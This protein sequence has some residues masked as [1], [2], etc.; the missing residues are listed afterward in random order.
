MI[1]RILLPLDSSVFSHTAI[2][3]ASSIAKKYDAEVIGITI[4]DIPEIEWS[5][6]SFNSD[7]SEKTEVKLDSLIRYSRDRNCEVVENF[8]KILRRAGISHSIE[9]KKG[10]PTN[11]IAS[12][13]IFYNLVVTGICSDFNFHPDRNN[14]K[15]IDRLLDNVMT[16]VLAVPKKYKPI[17]NVLVA[18]NGS[19]QAVNA[20]KNFTH[21]ATKF[22]FTITL[23]MSNTNKHYFKYN[24]EQVREY[25]NRYSLN[26]INIECTDLS[27]KKAYADKFADWTD[28]I[29]LG[30]HSEKIGTDFL[31]D[32]FTKYLI[33]EENKAL[34]LG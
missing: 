11:L 28:M 33:G 9:E 12:E 5:L 15:C 3:Y 34:F 13:A 25:M 32:S 31:L 4:I 1:K 22:D 27:I 21:L 24:L 26:H 30:V 23:L 2:K 29:V 10:D 17:K 16:P 19:L 7:K 8:E 6:S 20:L 18:F 14:V